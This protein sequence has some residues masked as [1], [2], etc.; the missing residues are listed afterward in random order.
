MH[1]RM[2]SPNN[3]FLCVLCLPLFHPMS[4]RPCDKKNRIK[5]FHQQYGNAS[6][7]PIHTHNKR[8]TECTLLH[9]HSCNVDAFAIFPGLRI[10]NG[11]NRNFT[12]TNRSA[13]KMSQTHKA[14]KWFLKHLTTIPRI[15]IHSQKFKK[16]IN[17]PLSVI[18]CQG[19][20]W[21]LLGNAWQYFCVGRFV[22]FYA[23]LNGMNRMKTAQGMKKIVYIQ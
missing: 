14:T 13:W 23:R 12:D 11:K 9:K 22:E 10:W 21:L 8:K 15:H 5:V 2:L 6:L 20:T 16:I 19:T 18:N 4:P 17:F 7:F 1:S 3:F